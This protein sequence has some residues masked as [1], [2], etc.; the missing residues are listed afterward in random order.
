MRSI[1]LRLATAAG[2]AGRVGVRHASGST[3]LGPSVPVFVLCA[4]WS[5]AGT[6]AVAV[7]GIV[8]LRGPLTAL[9]VGAVL[10]V[11]ALN[12]AGVHQAAATRDHLKLGRAAARKE[13]T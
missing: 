13:R 9:R 6:A 12:R 3:R 2:P 10:P 4:L 8:R 11:V 7:I 1:H 5:A